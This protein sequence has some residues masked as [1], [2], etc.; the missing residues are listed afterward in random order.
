MLQKD[1]QYWDFPKDSA[2]SQLL[3]YHILCPEI[4]QQPN[5]VDS[6]M[7]NIKEIMDFVPD[8]EFSNDIT[9]KLEIKKEPMDTK[10]NFD[11]IKIKSE[12]KEEILKVFLEIAK[13]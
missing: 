5:M 9:L 3:Y 7:P 12:V 6:K 10:S 11:G 4:Y 1:V 2:V 8:I 13:I